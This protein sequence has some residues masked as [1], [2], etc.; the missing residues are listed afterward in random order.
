MIDL[1]YKPYTNKDYVVDEVY[2]ILRIEKKEL[3]KLKTKTLLEM[4]SKL[5]KKG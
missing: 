3:K 1:S 4:L 5:N 2:S